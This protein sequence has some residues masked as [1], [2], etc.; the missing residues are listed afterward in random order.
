MQFDTTPILKKTW[1]RLII[2]SGLIIILLSS[3]TYA[4]ILLIPKEYQVKA[5]YL[6]NFSK[7]TRWPESSFTDPTT[8]IS[9]CILGKN[10]FEDFEVLIKDKIIKGR[11]VKVEYIDNFRTSNN[12]QILFVSRS[13]QEKQMK[14]LAYIKQYPVLTVSDI[15]NFIMCGGMIQ[16]YIQDKKVRF[17]VAPEKLT[18][19]GITANANLLRVAKI[20][21]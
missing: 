6:L 17:M 20:V 13:E 9:I 21:K 14:I 7:F 11:N 5:V 3:F 8:P 4:S 19:V 15:K 10:P 12:C 1:R 18:K 16:F 2:T